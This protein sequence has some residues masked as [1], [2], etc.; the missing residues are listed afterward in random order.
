MQ[1]TVL[2]LVAAALILIIPQPISAETK[3]NISNN[4][5]NSKST[6]KVNQNGSNDS[7][8]HIVIDTN[9]ERKEYHGNDDSVHLESSNGNNEVIVNG[10]KTTSTPKPAQSAGPTASPSTTPQPSATSSAT[11]TING[12]VLG[13]MTTQ[14]KDTIFQYFKKIF[15]SFFEKFF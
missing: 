9:G 8:T 3:I 11:I 6:V 15:S 14:E 13:E 10:K 12:E 2:G 7:E 5:D 4:G 1:K